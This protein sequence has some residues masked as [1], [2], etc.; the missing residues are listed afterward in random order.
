MSGEGA[1]PPRDFIRARIAEDLAT[2]RFDGRVV[3]RW[4]PEPNGYPHLGHA[5]A[6]CLNFGIAAEHDGGRCHLRMDDTNPLREEERFAKALEDGIRWLGY[7]W[8]EHLYYASD[9][10]ERLYGF[11]VQLIEK[12]RAYV[13]DLLPEETREYRGTLTEP[14]KDSPWRNR[15]VAENLALFARMRA[16][17]FETGTRT[18]RAKIDMTS[19][20]IVLRDPV[21]YRISREPHYRTHSEWPIYPMYD[22]AHCLSDSIEGITHSLCTLEFENNRALYDWILD[23][24]DIYHPQQIEFARS[25]VT[26]MLTSKRKLRSLV[27]QGHVSDWDDPR[28]PT[29]A[30]L[31]RRGYTP[32]AVRNF[33]ERVGVSRRDATTELAFLEHCVREDLN[34]SAPRAMA[35]LRP[36]R[37]VIE[38]YPEEQVEEFE[39]QR[40]PEDPAAGTRQVP[41]SRE[42]W[43]EREDFMEDPPRKFYRLGPGREVRLRAAYFVTCTGFEKDANGE[44]SLVRCS[45]DPETRGGDAPDGRKVKATLH[46]VSAAHAQTAEVRLYDT[47][48]SEPRPDD[49]ED[50]LAHLNPRS[51]EVLSD[52]RLEP[53]LAGAAAGSHWQ[54]ERLGYFCVD[55]DS[56]PERPVWNRTVTLRDEWARLQKRGG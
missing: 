8:G 25:A 39:A 9:Y 20:N 22:F 10:F 56:T 29:L 51:L 36:L 45:Y 16:G 18:L 42:L 34:A 41:F 52:C 30:G 26:H 48:F 23:E 4:P 5:T 24:L 47:L 11:A 37:L 44:V 43:I 31:R 3:T 13:C 50:Y 6:I 15:P 14:G 49:D 53:S 21:F 1:A 54:F 12:G 19:P 40:N 27:E 55:P 33:C 35:V 28:M 17:E 46:W 7:D 2:G 38:N 32:A